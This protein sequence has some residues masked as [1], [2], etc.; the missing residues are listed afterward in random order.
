MDYY[1][2]INNK[3]YYEDIA[4]N[5]IDNCNKIGWTALVYMIG[6]IQNSPYLKDYYGKETMW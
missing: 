3:D 5:L 1:S 4:L 6:F 2:I